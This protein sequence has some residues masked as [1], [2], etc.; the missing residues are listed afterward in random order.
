MSSYLLGKCKPF[1]PTYTLA[2]STRLSMSWNHMNLPSTI[3]LPSLAAVATK[4]CFVRDLILERVVDAA[5]YVNDRFSRGTAAWG[6]TPLQQYSRCGHAQRKYRICRLGSDLPL[7]AR[8]I[9]RVTGN[10]AGLLLAQHQ[11]RQN[12]DFF[13]SISALQP[14]TAAQ[15]CALDQHPLCL[16]DEITR[17]VVKSTDALTIVDTNCQFDYP[18]EIRVAI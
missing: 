11:A 14:F 17:C 6:F 4:W 10:E 13:N 5:A 1:N 2:P 8:S 15:C 12:S 7:A 18:L 3:V 9:A 16:K